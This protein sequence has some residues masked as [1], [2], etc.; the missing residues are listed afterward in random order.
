MKFLK[1]LMVVLLAVMMIMP[2]TAHAATASPSKKNLK[3]A[4]AT[5]K[6]V[7]YN[8]KSQTAKITVKM[9][10]T[11]LVEGKHFTVTNSKKK[12]NAGTYT[13]KIKGI[14]KYSGTTT[15]KYTVK[16]ASQKVKVTGT[17]SYKASTLKKKA[18]SFRLNV[19]RKANASVSF[20]SSTKKITVSKTG[21]VTLKKG[22]KKG[23]YKIYV[24]TK[25]TKNYKAAKKTITIRVK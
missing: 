18:K 1:R 19:T 15:V 24:S 7:T 14:G 20:K 6:A 25:S 11:T 13:L 23:T 17:K 9:G 4:Q 21:K 12:K 2:L 22:L 8:G 10:D 5:A 16:K 3:Y